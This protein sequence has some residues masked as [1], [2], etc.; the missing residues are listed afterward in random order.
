MRRTPELS[1]A[2]TEVG[3]FLSCQHLTSLELRVAEG[4][5]TRPA[6]NDIERRLLEKRGIEHERRVLE[7][8]RQQGREIVTVALR[9]GSDGA[10]L[11]ATET[12]AAMEQGADLIYQGVLSTPGWIGRPDFLTRVHGGG[13]S[14]P[15]HYEP[16]DAKLSREPKV[17]AI[18]QLCAY[19]EQL[20]QLQGVA[21]RYFHLAP[22]GVSLAPLP[23][24][25]ADYSAYFRSVRARMAE[26]V[27][28]AAPDSEPYPEP[29]EHCGV[30]RYWKRCEERRQRDDHLSLVAGIS[31]RQRDRLQLQGVQRLAELA[32]FD[33]AHPVLGIRAESL[34]KVR[35]QAALQL[36]GRERGRVLYELLEPAE[37][38]SGLAALPEPTPGDLFLDLEGDSF[39]LDDGLEYLFGLLDFG[40]PELDFNVRERPGSP[41]YRSF[42]ATNRAE[43]KAAFEQIIDRI[44]L[45]REEFPRLHL[46]HFGHREADALKKLSCRHATREAEVDQL[47]RDGVLVDLLPVVRH[48]LRASV[49]SYTLKELERLYGFARG[50][51][52]REA[53]RAMQLFGWWLETG[54]EVVPLADLRETIAAY[55][56]DDCRS[57]A[58]L[59]DFLEGLRLE[60]AT[61]RGVTLARPKPLEQK[62]P[63]QRTDRQRVVALLSSRL[64]AEPDSPHHGARRL[65][66]DL[67]EFHWREAKSGWWEHFRALELPA[68]DRLE[69]RSVLAQLSHVGEVGRVKQSIVHRY[70]FPEQEHSVRLLPSP[71]DPDTGE[72]PGTVVDLKPRHVDIKRGL[73]SSAPHPRALIV[74]KPIRSELLS[75]SLLALG[76]A[77]LDGRAGFEAALALLHR[78]PPP[79]AEGREL[80]RAG[81]QPEQALSRLSDSAAFGVLA[82]QG[83]PGSGKTYQ[84]ASLICHLLRQGKRVGVTASSHGVIKHLLE[85]VHQ[86]SPGLAR[87]LHLE[88]EGDDR[89]AWSFRIDSD[90]AAARAELQAGGVNLLGGTAWTWARPEF[91]PERSRGVGA[92][93]LARRRRPHHPAASRRL[94]AEDQA[95][96]PRY[97]RAHFNDI[98]RRALVTRARAGARTPAPGRRRIG[99]RGRGAALRP[100]HAS[101][102]R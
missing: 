49:E 63:E 64:L 35:R 86:L 2:A 80:L 88:E 70:E 11:S 58:R 75:D 76:E 5:L 50:A 32:A 85:R 91:A 83:P 61:E 23:L 6:Q 7:L 95:A 51:D 79:A 60:W 33:E 84:A 47:L 78:S 45:G 89:S 22:G 90:K 98:L 102:Q 1:F 3:A 52:L 77:L 62:P 27:R 18:L 46:F 99:A 73:R 21:P 14:W 59:R 53:A 66:A 100:R 96:P 87:G 69:D 20:S 48:A 42:W 92:G 39:V 43:E 81:E 57:T 28:A 25:T 16:M 101:R 65:L 38:A 36:R 72:S 19:A 55:N 40:E 31:R 41:R 4:Q 71:I 9:P 29:V 24:P 82:V 74:G 17:N 44:V 93:A 26:F 8:F 97:L 67:L 56:A 34:T 12:L 37:E 15:H 54:D 30:C 94:P 10:A 68:A 13:G